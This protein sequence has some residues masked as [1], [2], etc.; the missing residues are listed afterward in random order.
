MPRTQRSTSALRLAS[1]VGVLAAGAVAAA[2]AFVYLAAEHLPEPSLWHDTLAD[3]KYEQMRRLALRGGVD[4]VFAGDS[5]MNFAVQP[6]LFEQECAG[7]TAFNAALY[8]A[9]PRVQ[10]D[11]LER[12]VLPLL[13]PRLVVYG[14]GGHVLNDRGVTHF[15]TEVDYKSSPGYRRHHFKFWPLELI[16]SLQ[17]RQHAHT[18]LQPGKLVEAARKGRAD[19]V[20]GRRS[21]PMRTRIV[22]EKGEGTNVES[23]QYKV[24]PG[25]DEVM[26]SEVYGLFETLGE[27]QLN[28]LRQIVATC[29]RRGCEVAL[30]H[31]PMSEYAQ[32][33][34]LPGLEDKARVEFR[35]LA[36][37]LGLEY[38]DG[39]TEE[40][41]QEH[42]LADI[43]HLN[44]A[45]KLAFTSA[46][47]SQ[48]L[49]RPKT[50]ALLGRKEA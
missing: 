2:E 46:L 26:R 31:L 16:A 48:L 5:Q 3:L 30:V 23:N 34:T 49:G 15:K 24:R 33:M 17:L 44:R 37:E 40:F 4:V 47:A 25:M 10:L 42:Y 13:R 6:Q 12:V 9:M 19:Q 22:A 21:Y 27:I 36:D 1:A 11:W 39:L 28:A 41:E 50:A 20:R 32:N 38:I 7:V 29:R 35:A 18:V 8:R 14:I 43:A 45:G